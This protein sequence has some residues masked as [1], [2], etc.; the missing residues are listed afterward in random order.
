MPTSLAVGMRRRGIDVTTSAESGLASP[1]DAA[2]LSFAHS[3]GR[4]V[5]T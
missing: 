2:Q 1:D 4:V 5:V 3:S